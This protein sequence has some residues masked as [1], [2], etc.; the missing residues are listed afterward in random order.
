MDRARAPPTSSPLNEAFP[1][2]S[3]PSKDDD[4]ISLFKRPY[5]RDQSPAST[6]GF[7]QASWASVPDSDTKLRHDRDSDEATAYSH[8][9]TPG[10]LWRTGIWRNVP[11]RGLSSLV[12]VLASTLASAVLLAV[13]NGDAVSSWKVDPSVILAV[14]SAISTACLGFG[15]Y[16]GLN[17]TCKSSNLKNS[18]APAACG[19]PIYS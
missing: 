10:R 12:M 11:W 8:A 6:L 7:R 13:S 3:H 17:I 5:P 1:L 14:L 15:L 19:T 18:G 4:D 16:S 2:V 9:P